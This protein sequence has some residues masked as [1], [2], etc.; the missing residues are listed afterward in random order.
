MLLSELEIAERLAS[1]DESRRLI[2]SPIINGAHQI[3]PSS[4]DVRLGTDFSTLESNNLPYIDVFSDK[5]KV[6]QEIAE[7][8]K[9]VRLK[10][11]GQYYLHPGEFVLATTLEFIRLPPDLAGRIEGR[12]SWGRVGLVVHSTA[13]Y[14]DPGFKGF[15]TFE[16]LNS[17]RVPIALKPG[18]RI[19][20]ICFFR[21][22]QPTKIP[23]GTKRLSKYQGAMGVEMSK[24]AQDPEVGG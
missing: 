10:A 15:L 21:M 6:E 12:S 14:I 1:S 18:L 22:S 8:T 23:Y 16:L 9:K 19:G 17:G 3:G 13:G 20:Q 24:L 4:L 7:Y 5:S 2:V 11:N